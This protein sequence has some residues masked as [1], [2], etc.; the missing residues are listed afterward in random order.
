MTKEEALEQWLAEPE[1]TDK[2]R[3]VA[4]RL[5]PWNTYR[6]KETGQ[7]ANIEAYAE[8][9]TVRATCWY[10]WAPIAHSVFGLDPDSFE[11]LPTGDSER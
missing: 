2:V 10:E 4:R 11:I 8:D 9:G 3:E 1:R 5:P 6:L 7:I